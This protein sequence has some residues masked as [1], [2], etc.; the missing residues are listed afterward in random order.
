MVILSYTEIC[1]SSSILFSLSTIKI[2]IKTFSIQ[3]LSL[4]IDLIPRL[5]EKL[6]GIIIH[7]N[8]NIKIYEYM[9]VSG[10]NRDLKET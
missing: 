4:K 3:K 1:G 8:T 9:Y 6:H 2:D 7:D 5:K 10:E